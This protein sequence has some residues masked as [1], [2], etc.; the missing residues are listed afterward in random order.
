MGKTHQNVLVFVKG[1]VDQIIP[2]LEVP[3]VANI[4]PEPDAAPEP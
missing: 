3:P 4:A 1:D 2:R